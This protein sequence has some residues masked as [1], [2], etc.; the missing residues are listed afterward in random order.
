MRD[1]TI[2]RRDF[3]K[4]T[5]ATL[6]LLLSA[7]GLSVADVTAASDEEAPIPGPAV[8][9]GVIGLGRWGRETVSTLSR[10]TSAQVTA[11][12]DTYEPYVTRA[13]KT[14]EAAVTFADYRKLL[15]CP[16]VEAVIVVTPTH[17]HKEIVLAALQSGKHVY[18]EAP[19]SNTVDDAKAIAA[20]GKAS[21]KVFQAGQQGRSNLM[22]DHV[23]KFVKAGVLG[24]VAQ[25]YAQWNK[26][27]SWRIPART[28]ER[29][30]EVNW[31]LDKDI[32]IGLTGEEGIYW[33]DLAN[34]YLGAQPVAVTGFGSV[35]SW[36]D[37]REVPDTVQC[38][39]EYPNNVRMVFTSTLASSFSNSYMLFQG[40]QATLATRENRGWMVKEADSPLL[41]WEVYAMKQECFDETAI[42]MIPDA[43]K[44]LKEGKEPA[45]EGSVEPSKEAHYCALENFTRSIREASEPA[46]SAADGYQ[47][48][49][50]AIK[51]NEAVCSGKRIEFRDEW[52]DI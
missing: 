46:C 52:F 27:T 36:Q 30:K 16:E 22:Y 10:I 35:M 21:K 26:R 43:S 51:A 33:I 15:E 23:R 42:C 12:C 9:I 7:D 40:D 6:A 18:C 24:D 34:W 50:V 29:E 13:A 41:G 17:L 38:V 48:A 2:D 31:R 11:I 8:K 4:G 32:S 14:A 5:A 20:A 1:T 47:A 3:L 28:S 25:L 44:I 49:I 45:M 39:I 37:G 19:L